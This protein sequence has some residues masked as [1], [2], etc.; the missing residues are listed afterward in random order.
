VSTSPGAK[1]DQISRR[2]VRAE[3]AAS[4]AL[5]VGENTMRAHSPDFDLP[6]ASWLGSG[7]S[8]DSGPASWNMMG[9]RYRYTLSLAIECGF[10]PSPEQFAIPFYKS[11]TLKFRKLLAIF[12]GLS[13]PHANHGILTGV[14]EAMDHVGVVLEMTIQD[15][16]L[17]G[18]RSIHNG[19]STSASGPR[20]S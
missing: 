14:P 17:N 7:S 15:G 6:T 5:D 19:A 10:W 1:V 11:L 13:P 16:P 20:I 9:G 18:N 2:H 4:G 8:S 12:V 3:L